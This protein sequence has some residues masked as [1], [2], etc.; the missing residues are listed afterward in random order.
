MSRIKARAPKG[1]LTAAQLSDRWDVLR[2]SVP[3]LLRREGISYS[4]GGAVPVTV[5]LSDIR[6]LERKR[7]DLAAAAEAQRQAVSA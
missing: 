6:A 7:P 1:C 4:G 5:R 2:T 3:R